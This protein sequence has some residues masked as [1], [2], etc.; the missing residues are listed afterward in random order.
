MFDL[1][2]DCRKSWPLS[3]SVRVRLLDLVAAV[4]CTGGWR[5]RGPDAAVFVFCEGTRLSPERSMAACA[6]VPRIGGL[7]LR[8]GGLESRSSWGK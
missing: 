1:C 6:V 3:G 7:V 5:P 4:C 2:T 8:F